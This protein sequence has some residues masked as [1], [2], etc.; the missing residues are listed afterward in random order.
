M[1]LNP[2]NSSNLEQ[3]AFKR[4]RALAM[5][6]RDSMGALCDLY[7][8]TTSDLI[9]SPEYIVKQI[10]WDCF[11]GTVSRAW[12]LL[13]PGQSLW[14]VCMCVFLFSFYHLCIR[15]VLYHCILFHWFYFFD[16]AS[17]RTI[18]IDWLIDN[19]AALICSI[20]ACPSRLMCWAKQNLRP[21]SQAWYT[22]FPATS[23]LCPSV[24]A[25][26]KYRDW[27]L[28]ALWPWLLTSWPLA[29]QLAHAMRNRYTES[30]LLRPFNIKLLAQNMDSD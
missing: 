3:L 11:Q 18:K 25:Y 20:H 26:G 28:W 22:T 15:C 19:M 27:T 10:I 12:S 16:S 23:K 1:A 13:R 14:C 5:C 21:R 9:A 2:S 30:E 7:Q 6:C 4:L 8:M 17:G 24:G 29:K